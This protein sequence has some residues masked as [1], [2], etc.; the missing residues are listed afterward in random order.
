[1]PHTSTHVISF[2]PSSSIYSGYVGHDEGGQLTEAVRRKPYSVIL[3]DEVEKAHH[4]VWNVLLQVLDDGRLTDGSGRVVDFSNTVIIMTSN[5]GAQHLLENIGPDGKFRNEQQAKDLVLGEV[6]KFFRPE[7]L[8]R[9][10]DMVVFT[11]LTHK[12]LGHIIKLQLHQLAS[13]LQDRNILVELNPA[14]VEVVLAEAYDPIYGA[15]PLKRWLERHVVTEL[16]KYI[17]SGQLTNNTKV[18]IDCKPE[19]KT[20]T[21]RGININN[22]ATAENPLSFSF[23]KIEPI[24][25]EPLFKQSSGGNVL[26]SSKQYTEHSDTDHMSDDEYM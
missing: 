18:L 17:I 9:L 26:K 8:N 5:L 24:K 3:F 23:V 22:A 25:K 2:I 14:A 15:R 6:K 20:N 11:P 7:F 10:D 12:D 4:N 21:A 1:M 16:S 19:F 13:R